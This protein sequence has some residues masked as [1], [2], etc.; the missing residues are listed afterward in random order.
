M[1]GNSLRPKDHF[2]L[3]DLL[4]RVATAHNKARARFRHE[5]QDVSKGRNIHGHVIPGKAV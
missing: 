3:G 4:T 1:G 5:A 2:C